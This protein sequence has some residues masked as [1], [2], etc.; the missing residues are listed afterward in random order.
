MRLPMNPRQ[1][2]ASTPT[3]FSF[4]ASAIDVAITSLLSVFAAHDFE[5][6]H[7]VRRAE[8]VMPDHHLR[9]RRS[10]TRSRRCSSVD[11]FD[12][13][14]QSGF[15]ILSSSREDLLLQRHP[16]EHGFDDDV[17]LFEAVVGEL[18]RDQRHALIHHGLRKTALFDGVFV[19]LADDRHAAVERV[20]RG[21]L[22]DHR[23]AR[24]SRNSW[25]CR[26]PWCPRR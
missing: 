4:L 21:F 10:P 15:A 1:L 13:R 17:G 12:A 11:V 5:Q 14:M 7:H 16:F 2:P 18:R 26:R 6:P 19:V 3:L 25:R 22:D 20:L 24:R 9:T 8:E 23:N